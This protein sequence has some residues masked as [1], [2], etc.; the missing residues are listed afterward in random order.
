MSLLAFRLRFYDSFEVTSFLDGM[1]KKLRGVSGK[2]RIFMSGKVSQHDDIVVVNIRYWLF[3]IKPFE[4]FYS[5]AFR[6]GISKNCVIGS[7]ERLSGVEL[8]KFLE[9]VI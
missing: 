8:S 5:W 9:G 4:W 2:T 1:N 7:V 6:R 3:N